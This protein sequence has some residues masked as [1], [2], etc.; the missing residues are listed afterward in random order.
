MPTQLQPLI[1]SNDNQ[2]ALLGELLLA[3]NSISQRDLDKALVAQQ[4]MGGRL[5]GLL[6]RSGAL[7][8]THLLQALQKQLQ[9]PVLETD[10]AVPSVAQVQAALVLTQADV[11][12]LLQIEAVIWLAED[13]FYCVAEDIFA[14]LL[15][16]WL[17]QTVQLPVHFVLARRHILETAL[18]TLR[19]VWQAQQSDQPIEQDVRQLRELAEE[20]P[21]VELVNNLLSM[22]LEERASDIHIEPEEETFDIRYRIDGVLYTRRTLPKQRYY[23]VASR[24]KLVSGVDIAERRLPQDGRIGMRINGKDL[25]V[26]VSALPGVHGE[27]I[28]MRLLPKERAD[29]RLERLGL[30]P[31][32]LEL[33]RSWAK[34]PHGIVLVTGP[35][36]SGKSTTLYGVLDESNTGQRKI[37]TVED[38]VEV[39]LPHLTQVQVHSDIGLNFARALR[40][41]LR[42]DPD[43][44]MI[45]EIRD[46]E[47]AEIAVQ[48]ALTG[49]L[50]LS[51]LHTNDA[52]SAFTRLVDMGIDPFL[53]ATPV[54]AVQAQRL[55]RR[56]CE[57][58][59]T[60]ISPPATYAA[61]A[62]YWV[63][64]A[65]VSDNCAHWKQAQGCP[66]CQGTGYRGRVGIYELVEVSEQLRELV[67]RRAS[68]SEMREQARQEGFRD[69]FLDGLIKARQGITT[70]EEVLRVTSL[71]T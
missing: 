49:H 36:G 12:W 15:N 42:Q 20:A 54:I 56:L 61:D 31:D 65:Q 11:S 46:L 47:T 34:R 68:L 8:E 51:T 39:Q 33:M 14:P 3:Q 13:T 60:P 2:P 71:A 70:V 62:E 44:I 9:L 43:V 40:S 4:Q 16:E 58:C 23:A 48:S 55:V 38:P 53:A 21:V 5:G 30:L 59:S 32:H 37:I 52:L 18:L 29:L 28:V 63:K 57:H 66:Q 22:A 6:I 17:M 69:L 7:S 67:L 35:T 41:I 45:G 1:M 26:R 64:H 25:D 10:I 24:L 27:S 50:V 19:D